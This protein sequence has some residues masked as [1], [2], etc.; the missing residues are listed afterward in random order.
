VS[1]LPARTLLDQLI[2]NSRV[3][4]EEHCARFADAATA[5]GERVY[6]SMRQLARW[7]AGQVSSARPVAQRVAELYW[8]H[9]FETLVG[10]PTPTNSVNTHSP[11]T[12][13][14][15]SLGPAPVT[16]PDMPLL[17]VGVTA[18]VSSSPGIDL[19]ELAQVIAMWFQTL[20]PRLNRR[21]LLAKL[22]AAFALAAATPLFDVLGPDEQQR[23]VGTM[24]DP[25]RIDAAAI[26]HYEV[27]VTGLRK[28][29]AFLGPSATLPTIMEQ[30]R[31]MQAMAAAAP[32]T[33]RPR[34]LSVYAQ[35]SQL[36]A[37][38]LYNLGD[39]RAAN[40][41]Y[42]D[43]RTSAHDA[44]DT[45]LVTYVL[46]QM[47]QVATW[48]RHPRVAIDHAMAAMSWAQQTTSPHAHAYAAD[49]AVR[50]YLAAGNAG[51]CQR[52]LDDEEAAFAQIT[53]TTPM[54][55]WWRFLDPG[56]YWVKVSQRA[57]TQRRGD[58]AI[59]AIDRSMAS[60]DCCTPR[61]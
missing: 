50:A 61:R 60:G 36:L 47:S 39:Y 16:N 27:I 14:V 44:E 52:G 32:E 35:L 59:D 1:A 37:W 20:D 41:Y 21:D 26:G 48:Q 49:V 4:A 30:R 23:L 34:V 18:L 8:G 7:R 2:V 5:A 40:Y 11:T 6:L 25:A 19:T 33:L 10:P 46:A 15:D 45:D 54:A 22:S 56:F 13:L 12:T 17:P 3:T 24:A 53:P 57:L 28:Q 55:D 43:A 58:V 51:A 9:P 31:L 42:E 29:E 38:S